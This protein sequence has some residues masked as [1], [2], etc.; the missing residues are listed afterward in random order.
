MAVGLMIVS[1]LVYLHKATFPIFN[2]PIFLWFLSV[3]APSMETALLGQQKERE[4][5]ILSRLKRPHQNS[6]QLTKGAREMELLPFWNHGPESNAD[7][8]TQLNNCIIYYYH[9]ID[10][11]VGKRKT[12]FKVWSRLMLSGFKVCFIFNLS[13]PISLH[14]FL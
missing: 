5:I 4:S 7:K 9:R 3:C 12:F 8:R 14:H 1:K 10:Q 2:W 6:C 11:W 13:F